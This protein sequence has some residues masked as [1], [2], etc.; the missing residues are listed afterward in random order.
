S[1]PLNGPTYF[2]L[3]ADTTDAQ[4]QAGGAKDQRVLDKI[5]PKEGA[6][7]TLGGISIPGT[8]KF[9]VYFSNGAADAGHPIPIIKDEELLLLRAEAEW[10]T[11]D[12]LQD[13]SDINLVRQNSGLLPPTTNKVDS[14][15]AEYYEELLC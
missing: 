12:K 1:E 13:I 15:H 6:P 14:P 9:T 5:A 8:L 7:Q 4:T 3:A 10:F 2:A 11:G